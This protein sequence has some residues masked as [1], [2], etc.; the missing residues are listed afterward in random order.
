[1]GYDVASAEIARHCTTG[2]WHV[3]TT[4]STPPINSGDFIPAKLSA[5][6]SYLERK[7]R[8]AEEKNQSSG[9]S[10]PNP[11]HLTQTDLD[12]LLAERRHQSP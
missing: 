9:E 2:E 7:L 5:Y 4:N 8:A 6:T 10:R 3:L 11:G 12:Q 1:M